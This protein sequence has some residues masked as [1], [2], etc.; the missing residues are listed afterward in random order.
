MVEPA[1]AI[2]A[3]NIATLRPLFKNFF[4]SYKKRF[5]PSTDSTGSI[6]PLGDLKIEL[7]DRNSRNQ[8]QASEY[9]AEFAQLLGLSRVGVTTEITAGGREEG[10]GGEGEKR[11]RRSFGWRRKSMQLGGHEGV[12]ASLTELATLPPSPYS[13]YF[14]DRGTMSPGALDWNLGIKTTTTIKQEVATT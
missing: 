2:T 11:G 12:G 9:S 4:T 7:I 1:I 13:P 10:F 8:V 3:M 14:S 5:D 6:G